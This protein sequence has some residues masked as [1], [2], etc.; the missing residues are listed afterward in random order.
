AQTQTD[1]GLRA[2][3]IPYMS[4]EQARGS[5]SDFRSDQFSFGLVLF[6]MVVGQP[7]FKR[8]S[9]VATLYAIMND[10]PSTAQ[11]VERRMRP[12][13]RWIVERCLAKN[14]S[15]RYGSTTDLS[16]DL[17][18][19][20]DRLGEVI[21]PHGV[22]LETARKRLWRRSLIGAGLMAAFVAGAIVVT[23]EA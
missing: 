8:E 5:P 6:E 4:P 3:T 23:S 19:L 15:D 20:R 17:A 9:A 11:L 16:R 10:D 1:A 7:A 2:G 18:T 21:V 14:P 12:P 22:E 13:Y